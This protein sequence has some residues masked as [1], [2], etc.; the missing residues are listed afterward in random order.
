MI[1]LNE[2]DI[3]PHI[4]VRDERHIQRNEPQVFFIFRSEV[5]ELFAERDFIVK[6][7]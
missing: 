5:I 2:G 3:D 7:P 1:L 6:Q 4:Q